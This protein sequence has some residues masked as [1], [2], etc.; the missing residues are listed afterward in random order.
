MAPVL[1]IRN[2]SVDDDGPPTHGLLALRRAWRQ[3]T[4]TEK[5]KFRVEANRAWVNMQ[6]RRQA[7]R[8]SRELEA[9]Q[10]GFSFNRRARG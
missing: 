4:E 1:I 9:R 2:D 6:R 7:S 5:G 3:A 8:P 10:L